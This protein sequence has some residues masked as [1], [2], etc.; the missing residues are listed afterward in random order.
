[1]IVTTIS[2]GSTSR[3]S[4]VS[5]R[6][7]YRGFSLDRFQ[8][9]AFR[10][11]DAHR[12]LIVAAPT[13]SGKTVIAEYA[14]EK[15]VAV[16]RPV[17]YTAPIKALSNQKFRDFSERFPGKVGIVTGDVSLNPDAPVLIMTTEIYR[18]S[19]FE[20]PDRVAHA[21]YVIFDEIH[22]LSDIERGTV[23][24]ESILFAPAESR[25]LCLSATVSNLEDLAGWIRE[26]R[27]EALDVILE[28][29]R[30]VPLRH[31]F[32]LR[33]K[34]ILSWE[35]LKSAAKQKEHPRHRHRQKQKRHKQQIDTALPHLVKNHHLPCLYFAFNRRRCE[36]L[37]FYYRRLDLLTNEE[38]SRLTDLFDR[39]A[40]KFG[41]ARSAEAARMRS[42]VERGISFHH[43]GLLPTTKEIV[44]QCFASGLVKLL[45]ATETFAMGV[46]MPARAVVFDN[47]VKFDGV[48][49]DFI[50]SRDFQQMAGRAGRRGKDKTGFVYATLEWRDLDPPEIRRSVFS[51]P[52]GVESQFNLSYTSI[53]SL[54]ARL[55]AGLFDTVQRSFGVY[56]ARR[57]EPRERERLAKTWMDE[58]KG[59]LAV[60]RKLGYLD[61][62]HATKK[63][64]FARKVSGHELV[65]SELYWRGFWH[66]LDADALNVLAVA[67]VTEP[68]KN[69]W[70]AP[71]PP[72]AIPSKWKTVRMVQDLRHLETR[73]GVRLPVHEIFYDSAAA[74][75]AW[76]RGSLFEQLSQY[77]SQD[78]GDL[79]RA[80][81]QAIQLLRQ[82]REAI[83]REDPLGPI[84]KEAET[85]MNRD[86][87][88]A[89]RLLR[90]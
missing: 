83:P 14:I 13:G 25:L 23:W 34:G 72:E 18:N 15:A 6:L 32:Y 21:Q 39:L 38:R 33:G 74:V 68:K 69:E 46:N 56:Q 53:L 75:Y 10:A 36:E 5:S 77:T 57:A 4:L 87:V 41:T 59:K 50:P 16:S 62:G 90:S 88:D 71:P 79:V 86:E 48:Q 7:E 40:A 30:S 44:E 54:Y 3:E 9:E 66:A 17:I 82:L 55:G 70:N 47:L 49:I 81:R 27:G 51:E 67:V 73:H 76:S 37:A 45:F 60:L 58:L 52:E 11:I 20:S 89:E 26:V 24:E 65:A 42:L 61:D 80:F 12:S 64:E 63:G 35:E 29:T 1:M 22:F 19:L 31:I 85:K 8:E 43:A 78:P 84:L 2:T 28:K